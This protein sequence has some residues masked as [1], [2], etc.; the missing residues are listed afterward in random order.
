[1]RRIVLVYGLIAGGILGG[2]MFITVPFQDR[3]GFDRGMVI[4]YTTMVLAF[5]TVYFGIRTYG[6]SVVRGPVGFGRAFKVGILITFVATCCYVAAWEVVSRV[7][8]PDFAD[9]YAAHAVEKE[10]AA[11]ASAEAIASMEREMAEFREMYR[12]PLVRIPL[13][14]LEPLPVGLVMTLISA[15]LLGLKRGNA[16]RES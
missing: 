7:F 16:P 15:G 4:G 8:A 11:G 9:K 13:T 10:R 12:N 1:M 14:F 3:I 6:E 5:L 2:M